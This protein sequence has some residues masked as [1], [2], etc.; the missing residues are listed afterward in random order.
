MQIFG[1]SVFIHKVLVIWVYRAYTFSFCILNSK[2]AYIADQFDIDT[3]L[4]TMLH[5]SIV[6]E[7]FVCVF[8][9]ILERMIDSSC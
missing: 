1:S 4:N 6:R 3:Y 9:L 2:Y 7:M 8:D 5:E